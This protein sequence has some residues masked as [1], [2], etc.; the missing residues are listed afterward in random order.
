MQL[1]RVKVTTYTIA[2]IDS[3]RIT[4]AGEKLYERMPLEIRANTKIA[5]DLYLTRRIRVKP[6][7]SLMARN[8]VQSRYAMI[9]T[10]NKGPKHDY[11]VSASLSYTGM[12][13]ARILRYADEAGRK[14]LAHWEKESEHATRRLKELAVILSEVTRYH[15]TID[16]VRDELGHFEKVLVIPEGVTGARP[17]A[18]Q[19]EGGSSGISLFHL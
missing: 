2:R 18:I 9:N 17:S 11:Y 12:D 14:W 13:S 7:L 5:W 15:W 4:Q 3:A 16:I 19:L 10:T 8:G 1:E 6:I